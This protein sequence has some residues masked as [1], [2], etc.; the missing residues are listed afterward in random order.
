M[1]QSVSLIK[2]HHKVHVLNSLARSTLY[3]VIDC[4]DE[5]QAVIAIIELEP[6]VAVV[7]AAHVQCV[8]LS[9]HGT[10]ADKRPLRIDRHIT[11]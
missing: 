5:N 8:R 2:P 9:V 6:N 10:Q 11:V 1:Q 4:R 7:C 3:E